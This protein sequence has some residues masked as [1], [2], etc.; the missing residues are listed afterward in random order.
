MNDEL[1][2]IFDVINGRD[3]LADQRKDPNW[4]PGGA[5]AENAQSPRECEVLVVGDVHGRY[6][7]LNRLIRV[8][9]PKMILQCGDFGYFPR[10]DYTPED[11]GETIYPFEPKGQIENGDIPIHFC[12][13]NHEDHDEL[14]KFRSDPPSGHEVA[15]NVFYQERGSTIT[16]PDGRVVLFMGGAESI[17]RVGRTEGRD[18]FSGELLTEADLARLPDCKVDIVI[19]HTLPAVVGFFGEFDSKSHRYKQDDP[20]RAV[21]DEVFFRYQPSR[22]FFGHWHYSRDHSIL[23]TKFHAL[24]QITNQ[25]NWTWLSKALPV[26]DYRTRVDVLRRLAD[27]CADSEIVRRAYV[28]GSYARGD[29]TAASDINL[30]VEFKGMMFKRLVDAFWARLDTDFEGRVA[31]SYTPTLREDRRLAPYDETMP[32]WQAPDVQQLDL[33]NLKNRPAVHYITRIDTED[34]MRRL[35][36]MVAIVRAESGMSIERT[37][38]FS[39]LTEED[40]IKLEAGEDVP[41][42]T[43]VRFMEKMLIAEWIETMP[44]MLDR[45]S[46]SILDDE[47]KDKYNF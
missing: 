29:C 40:L 8:L 15:P 45:Y 6:E 39:L 20:S 41:V 21:L 44:Q 31:R 34:Y 22:W 26:L 42:S 12:D 13:G 47:D 38:S 27:V 35:G 24:D 17:D 10:L 43:L 19:S 1:Q 37:A 33:D 23:R 25:R 9:K 36:K 11:G 4:I 7:E 16:L 46:V 18:W 14:A 3:F 32:I 2:F 5:H 28:T 30:H